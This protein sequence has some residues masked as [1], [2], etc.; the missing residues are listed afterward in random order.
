MKESP[1]GKEKASV[2]KKKK[3]FDSIKEIY[4]DTHFYNKMF[5]P[6]FLKNEKRDSSFVVLSSSHEKSYIWCSFQYRVFFETNKF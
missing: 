1:K 5:Q 3:K 6:I 4:I 2:K